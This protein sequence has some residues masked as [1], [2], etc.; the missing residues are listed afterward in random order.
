MLEYKATVT[1]LREQNVPDEL[2]KIV[3]S[4]K[5]DMEAWLK[6][7]NT[8]LE[9]MW[10]FCVLTKVRRK[11]LETFPTISSPIGGEPPAVPDEFFLQQALTLQKAEDHYKDVYTTLRENCVLKRGSKAH[12]EYVETLDHTLMDINGFFAFAGL[13][14]PNEKAELEKYPFVPL[15]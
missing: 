12:K 1:V 3:L 4:Y 10:K 7:M 13:C 15:Q 6:E 8:I 2:Q 11:Y 5:L 14:C 9:K